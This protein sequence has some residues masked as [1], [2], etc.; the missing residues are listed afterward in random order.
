ME[1]MLAEKI[2]KLLA[3]SIMSRQLPTCVT[4]PDCYGL[5]EM[6][7]R[8]KYSEVNVLPGY[9]PGEQII[10]ARTPGRTTSFRMRLG[11]CLAGYIFEDNEDT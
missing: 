3:L 6:D 2:S 7:I 4:V 10:E 1:Q 8:N 9:K 11:V 5:S